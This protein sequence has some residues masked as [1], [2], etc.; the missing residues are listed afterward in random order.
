M[1]SERFAGGDQNY[2][3]TEQYG[4]TDRLAARTRLHTRYRTAPVP[5][6]RWV[7]GLIEWP[8]SGRIVEV[9]CGT[10]ELWSTGGIELGD[11]E[12]V[13]VDQSAAMVDAATAAAIGAGHRRVTGLVADVERLPLPDAH[14]SLV[15]ANH[16]LYHAT[17]PAGAFAE[18]ARVAGPVGTVM[19]STVG[20]NHFRQLKEIEHHLFDEPLLD[21]TNLKFGID[22]GHRLL[23]E[24]FGHV[25]FCRHDDVLAVTDPADVVA[26]MRSTPPVEDAT[27]EQLEAV[28]AVVAE[29]FVAGDGTM[30]ID[31]D[32][33]AFICR[34]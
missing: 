15:V 3:R 10:G 7:A 2:L 25:T 18:L 19:A 34:R 23:G 28:E 29:A 16:M 11:A 13:L 30:N 21:P 8:T 5:W 32:V 26:Y 24:V 14:A 17:D 31:K 22:N 1:T 33:G 27:A 9:G 4:S 6:F 20:P 12:L